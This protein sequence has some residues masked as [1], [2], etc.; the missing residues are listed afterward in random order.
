MAVVNRSPYVYGTDVTTPVL[1]AHDYEVAYPGVNSKKLAAVM[2]FEWDVVVGH[3]LILSGVLTLPGKLHI[4][5]V[6]NFI[7]PVITEQ[8][9]IDN[10]HTYIYPLLEEGEIKELRISIVQK[11]SEV[12][13]ELFRSAH[14][15]GPDYLGF[16]S[17]KADVTAMLKT[18]KH[19]NVDP[20]FIF[21]DPSIPQE[22]KFFSWREDPPFKVTASGKR[23]PKHYADLWHVA[24]TPAKFQLICFMALYRYVRVRHQQRSDYTLDSVLIDNGI[25]GKL[26]FDNLDPSIA[27]LKKL[28]WHRRM[29]SNHPLEYISYM[30]WDGLG[31]QKLEQ[32]NNDAG[33]M[34]S[35]IRGLSEF[36]KIKS[37][38]TRLTDD[39]HFTNLKDGRVIAS[40]SDTMSIEIDKELPSIKGWIVTLPSELQIETGCRLIKEHPQLETTISVHCHDADATSAYPTNEEILGASKTTTIFETCGIEGLTPEATRAVGINLTNVRGNCLQLARSLFKFPKLS[41]LLDE[42]KQERHLL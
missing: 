38:P 19:D 1:L 16:W 28:A 31:L 34:L 13:K 17:I 11:H 42:F 2:D 29:Q 21:S 39:M 9:I 40:C 12:I 25:T 32:K 5:V 20:S 10:L 24:T 8:H 4:A 6:R 36:N 7:G 26:H 33:T 23:T 41:V 30:A 14:E 3:G 37:T 27:S 18:L 22:Y 15:W 35:S